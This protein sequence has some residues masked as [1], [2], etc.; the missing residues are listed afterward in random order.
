MLKR[1]DHVE[2]DIETILPFRNKIVAGRAEPYIMCNSYF[3]EQTGYRYGTPGQSWRTASGQWFQKAMV[4]YVFGLQ[5]E[6]EG[7][8]INPCLPPSWKNC[9]ITKEFRGCTYHIKYENEGT[10]VKEICVNGEVLNGTLL[11]ILSGDVEVKVITEKESD[12]TLG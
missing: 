1:A 3:G 6:M 7:L 5:P 4:N 8:R 11:P 10:S 9:S 12:N 2:K